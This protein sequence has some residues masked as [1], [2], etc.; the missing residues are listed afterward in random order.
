MKVAYVFR[1]DMASTFQ[2]ATMILPQLE[3]GFHGVDEVLVCFS[4]MIILTA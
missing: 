3:E 2:L 1:S 4:L